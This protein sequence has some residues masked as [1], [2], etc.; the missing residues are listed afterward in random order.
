MVTNN[1]RD[2]T[3]A[4]PWVRSCQRPHTEIESAGHPVASPT[5]DFPAMPFDGRQYEVFQLSGG[6]PSRKVVA[7]SGRPSLQP[8]AHC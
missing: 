5:A 6:R 7:A 4:K 2:S 1:V 8:Q 3:A